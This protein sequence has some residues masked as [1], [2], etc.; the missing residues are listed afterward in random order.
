MAVSARLSQEY[1]S[2]GERDFQIMRTIP[3]ILALVS[4]H[5]LRSRSSRKFKLHPI[6]QFSC[7][8]DRCLHVGLT[9]DSGAKADTPGGPSR[10]IRDMAPFHAVSQDDSLFRKAASRGAINACQSNERPAQQIGRDCHETSPPK[11]ISAS[12]RECRDCAGRAAGLIPAPRTA[13]HKSRY[14]KPCPTWVSLE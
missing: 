14:A 4:S 1:N 13:S 2:G 5:T 6:E 9:L 7:M 3:T 10:A 8:S 12:G 11:A